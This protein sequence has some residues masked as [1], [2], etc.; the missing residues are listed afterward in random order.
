MT[1]QPLFSAQNIVIYR[2]ESPLI[3]GISMSVSA[4]EMVQVIGSNG[5]GKTTLLQGLCGLLPLDDGELY[6]QGEPMNYQHRQRFHQHLV[7]VGHKPGIKMELSPLE[8]LAVDVALSGA[9]PE[10]APAALDALGLTDKSELPCRVLSAGQRRRV[11]LSR[12]LVRQQANLWILDEP[13]TALDAPGR[14]QVDTMMENHLTGGGSIL[15]TSHQTVSL[16][17]GLT[18]HLDISA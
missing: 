5:A 16:N 8:N 17:A 11:A 3:N 18:R 7:Y 13:Y 14:Q 1:G 12:L 10:L 4:G 2:G 9:P 6:W 15:C